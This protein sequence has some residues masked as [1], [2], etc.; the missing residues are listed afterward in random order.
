[1]VDGYVWVFI[2]DCPIGIFGIERRSGNRKWVEQFSTVLMV[3]EDW[4]YALRLLNF[5]VDLAFC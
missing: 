2:S 5:E 4:S 1:M 3:C